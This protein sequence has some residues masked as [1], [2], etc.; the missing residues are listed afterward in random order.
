MGLSQMKSNWDHASLKSYFIVGL[1]VLM[2]HVLLLY[3][4]AKIGL[5]QYAVRGDGREYM[6]A[7]VALTQGRIIG[8]HFP[9]YS[10]LIAVAGSLVPVELAALSIPPFFHTLFALVVFRILARMKFRRPLSGALIVALVPP[11]A[12]V[13]TSSALADSITLFFAALTFYY[14]LEGR[15]KLMLVFAFLAGFTHYEGIL[16]TIPLAYLYWKSD[17]RRL[18]LALIPAVPVV[19]LTLYQFV[20]TGNLLYYVSVHFVFYRRVFGTTPLSYPFESLV[21]IATALS[22][23]DRIY[24]L[25]YV[26]LVL[27]IYAIGGVRSARIGR[28]WS[29]AF[30]ATFYAFSA[31]Y[32]GYYFVPRFLLYAFPSLM[33]FTELGRRKIVWVMLVLATVASVAYSI[34]FLLI[35]VPATGFTS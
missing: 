5:S 34:W 27:I 24:W 23:I 32:T 10:A 20:V 16:L 31:L 21:Y 6:A 8:T 4:F 13:Y 1:I 25:G 29:A 15:E 14:G 11:S 17:R 12:I 7:A 35:R 33:E 30:S 19:L 9:L 3:G 18:L 2:I 22:G 28:N 26:G